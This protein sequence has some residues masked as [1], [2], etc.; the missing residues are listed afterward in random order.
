MRHILSLIVLVMSS[1]VASV[2]V[3]DE[4][5]A[6]RAPV[7]DSNVPR[8]RWIHQ[9]DHLIWNRAALSA[10]K[11]HAAPLV[12]MV[13]KDIQ[14]W[15]PHYPEAS[16]ADRRAFWL[17]FMS[18]LAKFESTYNPDAVGAG[19]SGMVC[20][21]F[22]PRRPVVINAVLVRVRRLRMGLPI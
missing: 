14:T 22:C 4:L 7:R 5:S 15:C 9:T 18:A 11:G 17:G 8:T 10:L 1:N 21:K 16:D 3:S 2:S 20:C 12:E 19:A 6:L 13:P